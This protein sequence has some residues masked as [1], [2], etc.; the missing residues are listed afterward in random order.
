MPKYFRFSRIVNFP[1]IVSSTTNDTKNSMV[2]KLTDVPNYTEFTSL[3]DQ[4]A[5]TGVKLTF[6]FQQTVNDSDPVGSA[7]Y[8]GKFYCWSDWDDDALPANETEAQQRQYIK[9]WEPLGEHSIFIRPK[10]LSPLYVSGVASGYAPNI[11]IKYIDVAYSDVPHYAIKF[12]WTPT[13]GLTGSCLV[14]A[15]YY[16][17]FRCAR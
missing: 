13:P 3:F 1:N 14:T 10:S 9:V 17:K 12:L 2:F 7:Q 11:K 16:M 8:I 4:Y 6:K 15:K 5:L